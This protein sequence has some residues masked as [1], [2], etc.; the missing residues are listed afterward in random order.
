MSNNLRPVGLECDALWDLYN[1]L[2]DQS[3]LVIKD[4]LY[5]VE[6]VTISVG[7]TISTYDPVYCAYDSFHR[8]RINI[9]LMQYVDET[10][11]S[12]EY[13]IDI[14]TICKTWRTAEQLMASK[15]I[16]IPHE[17]ELKNAEMLNV[18]PVINT[19]NKLPADFKNKADRT[20]LRSC[21]KAV[22]KL[23]RSLET[24]GIPYDFDTNGE[25][26]RIIVIFDQPGDS[27]V[28]QILKRNR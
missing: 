25:N 19:G 2:K 22:S 3:Y 10:L 8:E 20:S 28:S 11:V 26:L 16:R 6:D 9:Y 5:Y 12:S 14:S 21:S 24:Q 13:V 7:K 1:V 15:F 27:G 17:S 23:M 18:Y 4:Q